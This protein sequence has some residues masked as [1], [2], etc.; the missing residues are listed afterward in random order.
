[1]I[2][3]KQTILKALD[4]AK[5]SVDIADGFTSIVRLVRDIDDNWTGFVRVVGL[6]DQADVELQNVNLAFAAATETEFG[7]AEMVYVNG[8]VWHTTAL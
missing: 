3:A 7:A 2:N 6:Y 5:N 8:S 4:E 1:M